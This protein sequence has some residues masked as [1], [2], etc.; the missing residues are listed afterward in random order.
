MDTRD[1]PLSSTTKRAILSAIFDHDPDPD[2]YSEIPVSSEGYFYYY[3]KVVEG[4]EAY[5]PIETHRDIVKLISLFKRYDGTRSSIETEIGKSLLEHELDDRNDIIEESISLAVRLLLM[6]PT[7]SLPS[8]GRSITVSGETKLSWKEGT[9]KDLV[10]NEI[11][12]QNS[13]KESVKLEKIF[14]AQNLERI[15]GVEIRW[16]SNLADHL[17]MRDDDSAVEVFHHASFLRFHQSWYCHPPSF[18]PS[19]KHK[20]E[21]DS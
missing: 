18:D 4:S 5:S 8:A 6:V 19:Y 14:N 16:T 12:R 10:N 2:T 3:R 17:R 15:A 11:M 21:I 9:I 13:M 7:G 1:F 20:P